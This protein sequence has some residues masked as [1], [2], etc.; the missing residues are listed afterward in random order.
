MKMKNKKVINRYK[1]FEKRVIHF[2][3][4]KITVAAATWYIIFITT[5]I[6]IF[7]LRPNKYSYVDMNGDRGKSK[8]CYYEGSTR[9]IMCEVT[10]PVQQYSKEK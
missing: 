9:Q 6:L 3:N 10:I 1:Q 4:Y 7:T 5:L 8:N 2:L